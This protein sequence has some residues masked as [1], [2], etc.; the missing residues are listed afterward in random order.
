MAEIRLEGIRKVYGGMVVAVDDMSLEIPHGEIVSLLGP[1][2]C[3]KTTT[4]RLIAGFEDADAGRI[5]INGQ[6]ITRWPP[7]KRNMA[8]IFQ[9]PVV[10][11]TMTLYENIA[12]PLLTLNYDK[13]EL[14]RIVDRTCDNFGIDKS[15][16][17][18]KARKLSISERQRLSL[19]HAFAIER[20]LNILDEPFSSIDPK[21]R[22]K[23]SQMVREIQKERGQT[24]IFVTHSQSEALTLS[25]KIAMMRDGKLLQYGTPDEIYSRPKNR[26]IGWFVGN[27]GMNFI[28]CKIQR[29]G[30]NLVLA[31]PA[32]VA[33]ERIP[34]EYSKRVTGERAVTLGIRPENV[35]LSEQERE[36]YIPCICDFTERV[37]SRLLLNVQ[38][39]EDVNINLK[40]PMTQSV[41]VKDRV[42]VRFPEEKVMLFDDKT[43]DVL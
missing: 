36:G 34:P 16:L 11:D 14:G 30:G 15:M 13:E 40:I 24:C 39:T 25:D 32:F 12:M 33:L 1:S 2:G 7:Q 22:I 19:A 26:F 8:M 6:D 42:Y 28:D 27:P 38:L 29:K 4:M 37:G 3:G 9:F 41:G 20:N 35:L 10:Y 43:G 23:L 5:Y 31:T 21:S 18:A 17:S